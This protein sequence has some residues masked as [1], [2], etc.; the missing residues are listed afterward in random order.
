MHNTPHVECVLQLIRRVTNVRR[1]I[2]AAWSQL[3]NHKTVT[4]SIPVRLNHIFKYIPINSVYIVYV[5]NEIHTQYSIFVCTPGAD[6]HDS[7]YY[8]L[9]K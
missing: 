9:D 4:F 6:I 2:K 8:V 7:E 3:C 5:Y 1:R